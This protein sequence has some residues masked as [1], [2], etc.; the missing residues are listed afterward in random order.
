MTQHMPDTDIRYLSERSGWTETSCDLCGETILESE[1]RFVHRGDQIICEKCSNMRVTIKL[2]DLASLRQDKLESYTD[3][4]IQAEVER[5]DR[6]APQDGK[7]CLY[8][9]R[10]I[11]AEYTICAACAVGVA[12]E[13]KAILADL[14]QALGGHVEQ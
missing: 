2:K 14:V 9:F 10:A 6:K 8:C 13:I 4:E 3:A 5:W 1:S 11:R 12:P 7:H